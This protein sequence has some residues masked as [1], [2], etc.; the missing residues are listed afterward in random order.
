M[1]RRRAF[2]LVELLVVIAII[3][4]L[5]GLLLPAVQMARESARR[6]TC[7][8]N[9]KNLALAVSSYA[10][11]KQRMPGF[12][13]LHGGRRVS[14]ALLLMPEMDNIAI[15]DRWASVPA[16]NPIPKDLMPYLPGFFCPSTVGSRTTSPSNT[17]IANIGQGQ[18]SAANMGQSQS[19]DPVPFATAVLKGFANPNVFDYWDGRNKANGPFIDRVA[20]RGVP[21][22]QLKVTMDATDFKDGLSNT[23]IFSE[24]ALSG[25]WPNVQ[26][27]APMTNN[28]PWGNLMGPAGLYETMPPVMCWIYATEP[29]GLTLRADNVMPGVPYPTPTPVLPHMKINGMLKNPTIEVN[30]E[31]MRPSSFHPAGVVVA[32]ADGSVR[33]ANQSMAYHVYQQLMTPNSSKSNQPFPR[34]ILRGDD[35]QD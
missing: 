29:G 6:T 10:S 11:K 22:F 31:W 2:T 28:A 35:V 23:I 20:A 30:V 18:R 33:F 16:A 26:T 17:Y 24:S 4:I 1:I 12:Q 7:T 27:E 3:G 8:N 13:E 19:V 5:A 32:F 14:W 34:Y 25:N 21:G 9:Q 15:F